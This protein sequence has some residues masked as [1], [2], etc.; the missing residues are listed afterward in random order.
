M[1]FEQ[2]QD[3]NDLLLKKANPSDLINAPRVEEAM[4]NVS[5]FMH[6][7]RKRDFFPQ[8]YMN[9]KNATATMVLN[10]GMAPGSDTVT[11]QTGVFDTDVVGKS[12][13]VSFCGAGGNDLV[14]TVTQ[15]LSA[16][17][18]KLDVSADASAPTA[19][20]NRQ[21]IFGHSASAAID[22]CLQKMH[23]AR[24]GRLRFDEMMVSDKGLVGTVGGITYNCQ[25]AIPFQSY[26]NTF[27]RGAYDI[28]GDTT[29]GWADN[30]PANVGDTMPSMEAGGVCSFLT[31]S[32]PNA[33]IFGT[34][35][36]AG[37]DFNYANIS[38]DKVKFLS[39]TNAMGDGYGIGGIDMRWA[40]NH[41]VLRTILG[42]DHSLRWTRNPVLGHIGYQGHYCYGDSNNYADQVSVYGANKAFRLCS[43]HTRFGTIQAFGFRTGLEMIPGNFSLVG[44]LLML[45]WGGSDYQIKTAAQTYPGGA[46]SGIAVDIQSCE[47]EVIQIGNHPL[48]GD[49]TWCKA[50]QATGL[51][52]DTL[53]GKPTQGIIK[54]APMTG[55]TV[56]F[57][58]TNVGL[59]IALP[60]FNEY[61]QKIRS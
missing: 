47:I 39:P 6:K 26:V 22:T 41:Q 3:A 18:V 33:A 25:H 11:A 36:P 1:D 59:G 16:T 35:G 8:D 44:Q 49:E 38:F 43:E 15:R 4:K 42:V 54:F 46:G 45:H 28:E 5:D 31:T 12:M 57:N 7:N 40:A 37:V 21:I 23:D 32:S 29:H 60:S 2:L 56:T 30:G 55:G 14:G 52:A 9:G 17:A 61:A 48:T 51:Y 58:P 24:R 27:Q 19:A 53:V 50:N 13:K 10:C 34:G 20:N